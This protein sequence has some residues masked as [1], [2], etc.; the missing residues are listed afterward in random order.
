MSDRPAC[1]ET[2][3]AAWFSGRIPDDWFP[4][5][6]VVKADR[7]EI[8]V[9]GTLG[10]PS[11]TPEGDDAAQV[12]ATAR[13]SGFREETRLQRMKIA[14]AA[15]SRWGRT[16]SWV[17]S[18]GPVE[19]RFTTASVPVMT[20]LRFDQRRVLDT[21]IDSGVVRS[22][23]EGLAW[24]VHQ[25][26]EHQSEWIDRLKEAMSEVERIRNDGP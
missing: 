20:R 2:E 10:T 3:T 16:V 26:G 25:V 14:E 22:R 15:Q 7:D 13:I 5:P 8:L 1:D 12:A 6:I 18:C 11:S 4:E 19:I 17:A 24:C 21:L 9:F 23:S